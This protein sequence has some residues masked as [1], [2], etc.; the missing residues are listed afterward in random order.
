MISLTGRP[1]SKHGMPEPVDDGPQNLDQLYLRET[2]YDT[3]ALALDVSNKLPLL[4]TDQSSV[5]NEVMQ[6]IQRDYGTLYFLD[7]PGGTGKTYLNNLILAKVRSE[8]N[9][10]LAVASSGIAATLLHGGRTAHATFKIPF[11]LNH[12]EAPTCNISK[13]DPLA[14]VLRVCK[15]IVWDECTMTHKRALEALDR[16]LQDLRGDTRPMGGMTVLL[17]G[18]FRQ[19]LPVVP[20]GTRADEVNACIKSSFLWS[21]IRTLQLRINMRVHLS[22]DPTADTFS[23]TLIQIGNGEFEHSDSQIQIPSTLCEL[24]DNFTALRDRIYPDLQ[25][26]ETKTPEWFKERAI[27]SPRNDNVTDINNSLLK[28]IHSPGR[29]YKSIDTVVHTEDTVNYPVE[30]LNTLEPPGIPQHEL[31]LKIGA[32]IMFVT[33]VPLNYAMAPASRLSH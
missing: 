21:C 20:R 28:T 12:H 26:I 19:T 4:N 1:L 18:D 31:H 10:A 33:S 17:A 9:I 30:F 14:A 8:N 16:T 22:K 13:Q 3:Q 23:S 27:L 15:I 24:V 25:T 5:F 2:S 11:D 29:T 7:A 6:S 32:P